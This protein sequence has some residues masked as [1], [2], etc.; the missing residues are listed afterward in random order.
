MP[1]F[2]GEQPFRADPRCDFSC[3]S[4]IQPKDLQMRGTPSGL[5]LPSTLAA[6]VLRIY[7]LLS[8][9]LRAM[10]EVAGDGFPAEWYQRHFARLTREYA[11]VVFEDP[12][13][14]KGWRAEVRLR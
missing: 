5:T 1:S 13:E 4:A 2:C 10:P 7:A 14:I 3:S 11:G 12:D 8:D 6:A 9:H